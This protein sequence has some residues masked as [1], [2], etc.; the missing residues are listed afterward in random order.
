MVLD[1][2]FGLGLRY[3]LLE[4]HTNILKDSL[5]YVMDQIETLQLAF[6]KLKKSTDNE[7]KKIWEVVDKSGL[8]PLLSEYRPGLD[9]LDT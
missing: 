9:T 1:N 5:G 6:N 7:F 3:L 8:V 4:V 2:S